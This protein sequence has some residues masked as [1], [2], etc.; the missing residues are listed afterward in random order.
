MQYI[1]DA[2]SSTSQLKAIQSQSGV[3]WLHDKV[4]F[5]QKEKKKKKK[6]KPGLSIFAVNWQNLCMII[7]LRNETGKESKKNGVQIRKLAV[8]YSLS[9]LF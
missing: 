9:L 1:F 3:N 8:Q 5:M 4:L 6:R 2:F 7:I